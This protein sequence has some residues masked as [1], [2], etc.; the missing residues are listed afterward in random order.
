[1]ATKSSVSPLQPSDRSAILN[2]LN[3]HCH[4]IVT[5]HLLAANSK[6]VENFGPRSVYSKKEKQRNNKEKL[7]SNIRSEYA[8]D[9]YHDRK[10]AF[11]PEKPYAFAFQI[12]ER[13]DLDL[14]LSCA[15]MA[16]TLLLHKPDDNW[17]S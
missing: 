7:S 17:V 11:K 5:W 14:G 12:L 4:C 2:I 8:S 9:F 10:S 15:F 1:M 6:L 3:Y 16:R 13:L